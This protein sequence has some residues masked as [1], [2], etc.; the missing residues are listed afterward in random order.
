MSNLEH[1]K[2]TV[3]TFL[4]AMELLS[5]TK[6]QVVRNV[7]SRL[8]KKGRIKRIKKGVYLLVPFRFK[9]WGVHEFSVVPLLIKEYYI[10]YI[11]ERG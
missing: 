6:R 7:L 3:F 4:D 11:V 2:K 1:D 10:S 8:A 5:Y 9:D